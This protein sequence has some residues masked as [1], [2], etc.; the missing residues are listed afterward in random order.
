[1]DKQFNILFDILEGHS[2]IYT[3]GEIQ[4][5]DRQL[6]EDFYYSIKVKN[7][8]PQTEKFYAQNLKNL[9]QYA[10]YREVELGQITKRH[11]QDYIVMLLDNKKL[12][13]YSINAQ[14]RAF[15]AFYN[16]LF[17]E[18]ILSENPTK[19]ITPVKTDR[20]IR[21]ILN[22]NQ[23]E[24]I[25][26]SFNMRGASTETGEFYISRNKSLFAFMLDTAVRVGEAVTTGLE[27]L[28]L[29][30]QYVKVRGKGRRE[31]YVPISAKTSRSLHRYINNHRKNISG[32][33]LFCHYNGDPMLT[34]AVYRLFARKSKRLNIKLNP[35]LVRHTA[36]THMVAGGMDSKVVQIL[37]GQ[38]SPI[39]LDHYIHLNNQQMKDLH[40]KYTPMSAINMN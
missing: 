22:K 4:V 6:L 14:I 1:M 24:M 7:L 15:K 39:V 3:S 36:I 9:K 19:D 34:E 21:E 17:K 12:S 31:R 35:H 18:N 2:K 8:S 28:D 29:K 33:R 38:R 25:F 5:N 37:V 32:D 10:K 26:K 20:V 40:S 27:D 30:E 11:I 23:I 13:P 16:Y